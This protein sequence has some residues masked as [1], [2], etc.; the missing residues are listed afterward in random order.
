[1]DAEEFN[2]LVLRD[3]LL[4]TAR[5][6]LGRVIHTRYL[7]NQQGRKS[8]DDPSMQS[9][10]NFR[11][12]LRESNRQQAD[13]ITAKLRRIGCAMLPVAG[14]EPMPFTFTK[15]EV[16]IMAEVEPRAG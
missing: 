6:V 8:P 13:D 3:V 12:D 15:E 5:E 2:R 10:E 1:M 7:V 16:E 4:T 9:W 11:E 14:R